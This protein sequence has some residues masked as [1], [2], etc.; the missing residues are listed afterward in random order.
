MGIHC[1]TRP[2]VG[3]F[4]ERLIQ[5]VKKCPKKKVGKTSLDYNELNT[6]LIETESKIN[7]RSLTYILAMMNLFHSR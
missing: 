3:R 4:W 1:G 2:Q 7:S 6:V 5:T